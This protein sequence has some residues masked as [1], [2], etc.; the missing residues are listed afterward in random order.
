MGNDFEG[1]TFAPSKTSAPGKA[2]FAASQDVEK[3]IHM[4][5][6]PARS[7]PT[8]R[9]LQWICGA[10]LATAVTLGL[11]A[12]TGR[13]RPQ[14]DAL[15]PVH[16]SLDHL[17]RLLAGARLRHHPARSVLFFEGDAVRKRLDVDPASL[18]QSGP[19]W[20]SSTAEIKDLKNGTRTRVVVVMHRSEIPK[21]SNTGRL[22]IAALLVVARNA[23]RSA[24]I[25]VYLKPLRSPRR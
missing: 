4:T 23:R 17:H 21:S 7:G 8:G 20:Y 11:V 25:S 14:V 6:N 18:R 13:R 10:L 22:A 19:H 24:T 12:L 9:L 1:M 5:S 15:E 16:E 2:T 3:E